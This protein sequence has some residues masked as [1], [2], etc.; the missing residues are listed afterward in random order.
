MTLE[1]LVEEIQARAERE[2][3]DE[4]SRA[5][6]EEQTIVAE[7]D[8]KVRQIAEDGQRQAETDATRERFQKLASAKLQSRKLVY[9]TRERRTGEALSAVRA[10]LQAYTEA[11]EYPVVLKR[12]FSFA[13]D[14]L[15]KQLRVTGRAEDAAVL[16]TVAGKS[17]DGDHPAAILGGLIAETPDG[18]RRLNLSFDELL[19]LREDK[20][21]SLL[22]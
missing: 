4:R 9:E 1:R 7:R 5:D 20:V 15:G 10:S 21:R 11:P 16:R 12:M 13:T 19:R 8:R 3:A 18:N 22:A 14:R 6:G 17:F 2:L